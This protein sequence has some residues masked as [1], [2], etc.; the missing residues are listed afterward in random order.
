MMVLVPL[1][2]LPLGAFIV[3]G[4]NA[5]GPTGDPNGPTGSADP[6][7]S[8]YYPNQTL[9]TSTAVGSAG[10]TFGRQFT[11]K[12]DGQVYAQPLVV[13]GVL[14]VATERNHL[15][16]LDPVTG[17]KI[18]DR[19]LGAPFDPIRDAGGCADLAPYV[20]VTSTPTVDPATGIVYLVSKE[21]LPNVTPPYAY[22]WMHAIDPATGK[23]Q[24][25]FPFHIGGN[26]D[27]NPGVVFKGPAHLQRP[28]LLFMN[29]VIYAAFASHCDH[30]PYQ[31]WVAGVSTTGKRVAMWTTIGQ[32]T[33]SG[34]GIWQ[35]GGGLVSDGAGQILL[36]TGNS[37]GGASPTGIKSTPPPNLGESVVRLAV[38]SDGKLKA[39]DFFTPSD[40]TFLDQ[41]DADFGSGAPVA[42]PST[43]FSTTKY[44]NLAFEV[45]KEGYVY[46]LNRDSLGGVGNGPGGSDKYVSRNGNF[47]GV[48]SS[49]AVW[50]GDGGYIYVPT[51]GPVSGGHLHGFKFNNTPDPTLTDSSSVDQFGFGSGRPVVTSSGPT[52]TGSPLVWVVRANGGSGTGSTL[53]AYDAVPNG[54]TLHLVGRWPVGTA[55][56]FGQPGVYHSRLYLGT[57]D[58][59]VLGFG[60]KNAPAVAA[61][62]PVSFGQTFVGTSA[63]TP[64]T[65]SSNKK[66]SVRS[67]TVTSPDFA[68]SAPK[69]P[70]TINPHHP[71]TVP[72]TFTP[73]TAGPLS[74]T[75]TVTTNAGQFDVAL[76]GAGLPTG[77]SLARQDRGASLGGTQI[78]GT[79][80][81]TVTFTNV[82]SQ[83]LTVSGVT[84][85][86]DPFAVK[87]A[88]AP[89][90]VIQPSANFTVTISATPKTAGV[91]GSDVIVNSNGGNQ[92]VMVTASATP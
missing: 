90:T 80:S 48:W 14:F 28:A 40:S 6:M 67:I 1:L 44:A 15:Y 49:P 19:V 30:T 46:L 13:N 9:L 64:A 5:A 82:G 35:S 38:Q 60:F 59:T 39:T 32:G 75:M 24:P 58:Q 71:L 23:E 69:G 77:P 86:G 66:L 33:N 36:A 18:W 70:V 10:S 50:P 21:Y 55:S 68:V 34:A 47:S 26:A 43:P 54:T 65:L 3:S 41:H 72:V 16:G 37:F 63:N 25:G 29:G 2:S 76:V 81:G 8:G 20:G 52:G 11:I 73:T 17:A 88:P 7:R 56:K 91:F 42:L 74:A 84:A 53:D 45:G 12:V 51:S 57:R 78:G 27:N 87:D 62:T 79:V 92:D 61:A 85:P 4:A 83:P 22:Q 89:N 31:G